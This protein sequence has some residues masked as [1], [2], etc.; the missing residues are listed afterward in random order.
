MVAAARFLAADASR[1]I[2]QTSA[3]SD[4]NVFD[5]INWNLLLEAVPILVLA[6][7]LAR[8]SSTLLT[9]LADRFVAARFRVTVLIPVFKLAIYGT[10]VYLA[11]SILFDLTENQLLALSGVAG[12]AVGFGLKDLLADL[13]GGLALVVEQP[14]QIGDKVAIGEYYGEVVDIGLRSTSLV[15]PND[16]LVTVPNYLF[17]NESI[18]NGNAGAAEMLITVEFYVDPESDAARARE[19]VEEAMLTSQYV[20]VTDDLPHEVLLDDDIHY[21]KITGKA[22][23]NDLRNEFPFRTDVTKRALAAFDREGIESPKVPSGV[24][25]EIDHPGVD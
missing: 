19:L 18:A 20:Y 4:P 10:A 12:A 6:Y 2:A 25:G 3:E 21:R 15:T 8:F 17:F 14:Y 23:V 9:G 24:A 13:V 1:V 7:F 5:A 16:N 11:F 22:Y